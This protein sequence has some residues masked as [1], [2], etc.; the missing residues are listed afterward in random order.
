MLIG[1]SAGFVNISRL[2]GIHLAMKSGMLAAETAFEMLRDKAEADEE[3]TK[4]YW[5]RVLNSWIFEELWRMR[6]FRQ[7]F[8]GG[9]LSGVV[10]SGLTVLTGGL[11]PPG[12]LELLGDHERMRRIP[13]GHEHDHDGE[14]VPPS[15]P[16]RVD[17]AAKVAAARSRGVRSMAPRKPAVPQPDMTIKSEGVVFDKVT[18]VYHSGSTHEEDQPAHLVVADVDICHNRCTYEYGNPCQY[19]CP[20]AV[21]EMAEVAGGKGRQLRLNF[22]NCVHCKTCDIRDPYQIITWVTPEGGGGPQY[23]GL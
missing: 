19:F 18:D 7:S 20:A 1:A 14:R 2:K 11:L 8:Q 15:L 17:T 22:S 12:R 6:N 3:L 13:S 5:H 23:T 9:F 4:R 21:Y 16:P 10:W